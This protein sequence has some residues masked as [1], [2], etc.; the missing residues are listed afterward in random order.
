MEDAGKRLHEGDFAEGGALS[1]GLKAMLLTSGLM[2]PGLC[3]DGV[4]LARRSL[5]LELLLRGV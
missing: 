3:L 5:I 1:V 4:C 2:A